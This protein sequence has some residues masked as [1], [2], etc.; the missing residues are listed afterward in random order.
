MHTLSRHEEEAALTELKKSA[1]LQCDSSIKEF[2]ECSAAKGL[3]VVFSC[4][5]K[6]REMNDCL[7]KQTTTEKLDQIRLRK[8]KKKVEREASKTSV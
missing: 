8:L 6:L 5:G 4:R 1:R 3:T 2:A 7:G